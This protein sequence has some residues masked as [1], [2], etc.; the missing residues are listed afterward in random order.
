MF[1][2]FLLIIH[3]E[4]CPILQLWALYFFFSGPNVGNRFLFKRAVLVNKRTV[5]ISRFKHAYHS[6]VANITRTLS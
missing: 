1:E 5:T 2:I 3:C 6:I 4:T